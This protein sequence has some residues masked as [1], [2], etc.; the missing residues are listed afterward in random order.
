[1]WK[2][3]V[4]SITSHPQLKVVALIVAIVVWVYAN[5]R[6]QQEVSLRAPVEIRV[7]DGYELV[8]QSHEEIN[9]RL[10]GPQYIINRRQ[11]QAALG[12][13]TLRVPLSPEEVAGQT[14]EV[15]ARPAWLN[16]PDTELVRMEVLSMRPS[17]LRVRISPIVTKQIPVNVELSGMPRRGYQ[18]KETST[19]PPEVEVTGPKIVVEQLEKVST[20]EVALWDVSSGFRR[21]VRLQTRAMVPVETGKEVPVDFRVK[22]TSVAVHVKTGR[23]EVERT[24]EKVPV[25]LMM[26]PDFPFRV[27]VGEGESHVK[28]VISGLPQQ[29]ENLTRDALMAFVDVS[30][31][32][33]ETI[34]PGEK[35]LYKENVQIRQ[36]GD[37][38]VQVQSVIPA[39]V[40]TILKNTE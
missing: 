1:M 20:E 35:A 26:P 2:R 34:Q 12:N 13:L 17:D 9:L 11:E 15:N 36:L 39:K 37:P 6:V 14:V 32:A 16:I 5:S 4:N 21:M 18:I 27:Q 23:E 3:L 28:V 38:N 22:P 7:P 10:R 8:Y 30:K 31:L 19:V 24:L 40:T 29:V 33:G 25:R